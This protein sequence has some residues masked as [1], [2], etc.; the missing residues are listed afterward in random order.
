[1][2]KDKKEEINISGIQDS[3]EDNNFNVLSVGKII[4]FL[5]C[6]L[7]YDIKFDYGMKVPV[8]RY[9]GFG[10][11]MH[12]LLKDYNWHRKLNRKVKIDELIF[13][14]DIPKPGKKETVEKQFKQYVSNYD[15]DLNNVIDLEKAFKFTFSQNMQIVGRADLILKRDKDIVVVDFKSGN[16]DEEKLRIAKIQIILYALCLPEYKINRGEVYFLKDGKS[17]SFFIS[18]KDKEEIKCSLKEIENYLESGKVLYNNNPKKANYHCSSCELNK[19]CPFSKVEEKDR[20][21]DK[22]YE[23]NVL[24][25]SEPNYNL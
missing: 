7:K 10:L 19:I 22:D 9:Y 4:E 5:N 13:Q 11:Y 25:E 2:E 3:T 6:P 14:D 17:E 15:S 8:Q 12:K 24:L 21:K 1:M 16:K 18:E 20:E 23:L